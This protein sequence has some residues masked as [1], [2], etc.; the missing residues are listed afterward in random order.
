MTKLLAV[1]VQQ[2]LEE[3]KKSNS[4]FPV[5]CPLISAVSANSFLCFGMQKPSDPP[6][7]RGTLIITDRAMD[8]MAPFIHEFT[9]QAMCND[10]LPIE[11][12]TKYAYVVLVLCLLSVFRPVF[13]QL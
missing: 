13:V 3:H 7:P 1:M 9:Y 10:L 8:V 11:D 5:I 12:G 2:N 6:Q 4:D